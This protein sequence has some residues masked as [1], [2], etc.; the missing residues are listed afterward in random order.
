MVDMKC[1]GCVNAVK[2]KLETIEGLEKVDVDGCED[3][4]IFPC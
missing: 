1:E 4:W 3:T 2:S